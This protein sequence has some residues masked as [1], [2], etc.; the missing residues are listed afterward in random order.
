MSII[1]VTQEGHLHPSIQFNYNMRRAK[2]DHQTKPIFQFPQF[3]HNTSGFSYVTSK[4][5]DS[6]SL[7][8][9]NLHFSLKF[10]YYDPNLGFYGLR[11]PY[12]FI[13]F[14]G[15]EFIGKDRIWLLVDLYYMQDHDGP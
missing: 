12:F 8:R 10:M 15:V 13:Q 11:F 2:R 6:I 5:T 14:G 4:V 9:C 3:G 7:R 1:R